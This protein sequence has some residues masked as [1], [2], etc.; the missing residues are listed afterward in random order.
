MGQVSLFLGVK[1]HWTHHSDGHVTVHL[2]QQSFAETL[3]EFMGF[4][5]LGTSTFLTPYRSGLP[6]N[7]IIHESMLSHER[8]AL[9]LAYQS[10]VRSLNW[11]AMR[12]DLATIVSLLAQH[13][14]I[15]LQDI[16]KQLI[17]LQN[18]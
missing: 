13:Q 6:V 11:L 9:R 1:F 10:L 2:T 12:P 17:M 15:R 18:T 5:S 14:A 4:D 3:I 7:S 16:W 8:D